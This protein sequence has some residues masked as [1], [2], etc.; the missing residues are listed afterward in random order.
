MNEKIIISIFVLLFASEY[1]HAFENEVSKNNSA[2]E[3]I[4]Y[5]ASEGLKTIDVPIPIH[6]MPN[7]NDETKTGY[8]QM[9]SYTKVKF[10]KEKGKVE[11]GFTDVEFIGDNGNNKAFLFIKV[12]ESNTSPVLSW[13]TVICSGN[14]YWGYK[15][16]NLRLPGYSSNFSINENLCTGYPKLLIERTHPWLTNAIDNNG[17]SHLDNL[18]TKDFLEKMKEHNVN[19]LPEAIGRFNLDYNSRKKVL[20]ITWKN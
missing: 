15:G 12:V 17:N 5:N 1:S 8:V 9:I 16:T 20:K 6:V 13:A 7:Y 18:C 2:F 4:L 14:S 10:N 11:I 19:T 3:Q